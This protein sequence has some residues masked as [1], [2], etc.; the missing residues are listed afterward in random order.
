M[1]LAQNV[2]LDMY[3]LKLINIVFNQ[4][5]IAK[6]MKIHLQLLAKNAWIIPIFLKTQLIKH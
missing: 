4:L 2:K 6:L 3:Q 5:T 1:E